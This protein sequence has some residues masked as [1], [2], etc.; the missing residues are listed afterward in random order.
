MN[1]VH[2]LD[3]DCERIVDT[4]CISVTF[5][6]VTLSIGFCLQ[7]TPSK[8]GWPVGVGPSWLNTGLEEKVAKVNN[9]RLSSAEGRSTTLET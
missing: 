7:Q 2:K 4:Y 3:R 1:L 8:S 9:G 5:V 6:A